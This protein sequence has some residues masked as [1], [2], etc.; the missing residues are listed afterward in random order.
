M[1][2]SLLSNIL[3]LGLAASLSSLLVATPSYAND[4]GIAS[5]LHSLRAER[6]KICMVGHYHI[7]DSP[8]AFASRKAAYRAAIH[9]WIAFTAAEYGTDWASYGRAANRSADC[10]KA[11]RTSWTCKVKARPCRSGHT[12]ARR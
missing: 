1:Y 10:E 7:G 5:V 9:H 8:H 12:L 3:V 4:T 11:S 6:G 2:K